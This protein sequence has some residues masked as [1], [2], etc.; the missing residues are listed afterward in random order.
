MNKI[1]LITLL[2]IFTLNVFSQKEIKVNES[3]ENIADGNNNCLS[4]VIFEADDKEV[5]KSWKKLMKDYKAKV[6]VKKE[7][8]ADDAQINE[9]SVNSIDV[10][11]K[12]EKN[13][14]GDVELFVAFDLGGAFLSS[15][16][17]SDKF[18]SAKKIMKEFGVQTAK[19]AVNEQLKD[20]E[21]VMKKMGS[22]KDALIKENENFHKKIEGW[23]KDIEK[24]KEDIKTNEKNQEDKVKEIEAQQKVL[25][26]I[27]EKEK[28]IK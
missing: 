17:H 28:M 4:V 21:K 10:Y 7:I 14:D 8:F 22:E 2:S 6:N 19:D 1:I 24:A 26:A 3:N 9:I 5:E 23:E 16:Q 13:K 12:T 27:Q 20:A 15:S 18:K 11:A 25:E